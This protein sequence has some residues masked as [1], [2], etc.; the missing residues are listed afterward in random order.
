MV[1]SS[2]IFL[3]TFMAPVILL[4]LLLVWRRPEGTVWAN[5]VLLASSLGLYYWG[6]GNASL[7]FIATIIITWQIGVRIVN[8]GALAA[9]LLL[10][11][12]ITVNLSILLYYKYF[13]FLATEL[14]APDRAAALL[15][16]APG[17]VNSLPIGISFYTFMAISYLIEI[18]R[19]T[20][21]PATLFNFATYLTMFPHLVA[22][23]IVRYS[24]IHHQVRHRVVTADGFFEGVFRF[25]LGL[26]KKVLIA[27]PLGKVSDKIFALPFDQLSPEAA[28]LGIICYTFQIFYD[29]SGYTDMA[30]GLARMMG[31]QF[32]ENFDNPYRAANITEFWRRWHMT[33][34]R[35]F[36]DYLYFSLGGNRSGLFR[37]LIN[38]FTVFFLCGL[39]HGANWTFVAWG[40]YH[41]LLL[42]IE[43]LA[44]KVA[45]WRPSGVPGLIATFILVAIGWVFFR[46]QTLDGAFSFLS[47][48][49]GLPATG[50]VGV[51][52]PAQ[53]Q[54][55][56][57]T[58][59]LISLL[60]AAVIA[61]LPT[62]RLNLK[63]HS[64]NAGGVLTYGTVML[65]VA[66]LSL[67]MLSGATYNPFI[68][69]RF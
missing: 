61:F 32:P 19:R 2:N 48:M 23:P 15:A 14:L 40:M 7:A 44:V 43:R 9:R 3:Y 62:N 65:V 33:L 52:I 69:F 10:A 41:G 21:P 54:D 66:L 47:A 55:L 57:G 67:T 64:W 13:A 58:S 37:T 16:L 49:A 25:S 38:L 8:A 53:V 6:N 59:S 31:F 35:W 56:L 34:T 68:Y 60:A 42:V 28:W 4:H 63:C 27:D 12:G 20:L 50:A 51:V 30:I 45:G 39:W 11:V 5:A 24:E 46:S 22:G 36:R 17:G 1:F 26:G 29:F 18:Y